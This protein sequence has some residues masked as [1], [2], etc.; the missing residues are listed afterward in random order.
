MNSLE[1][2]FPFLGDLLAPSSPKVQE[3][4]ELLTWQASRQAPGGQVEDSNMGEAVAP[5]F[6]PLLL[7]TWGG[8]PFLACGRLFSFFKFSSLAISHTVEGKQVCQQPGSN[9]KALHEASPLPGHPRDLCYAP[10]HNVLFY[11]SLQLLSVIFFIKKTQCWRRG[12]SRR[13]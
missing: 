7:V 10:S 2:F 11:F 6:S 4:S 13:L 5:W 1:A 3:V 12:D 9:R 8:V